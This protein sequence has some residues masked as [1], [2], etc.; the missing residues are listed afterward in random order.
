[1][2]VQSD[3]L[4]DSPNPVISSGQLGNIRR[5]PPHLVFGERLGRCPL[6]LL[7]FPKEAAY[8]G[9]R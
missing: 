6:L 4:T 1:M 2:I 3:Y 5:D 7:L 9:V 8:L